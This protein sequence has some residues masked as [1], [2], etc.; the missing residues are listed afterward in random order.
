MICRHCG[1]EIKDIMLGNKGVSRL[2]L[3]KGKGNI[4]KSSGVDIHTVITYC[5]G[6]C[7][8]DLVIS[9]EDVVKFL[10]KKE[11]KSTD[12]SPKSLLKKTDDLYLRMLSDCANIFVARSARILLRDLFP[13]V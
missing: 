9:Q 4:L 12:D 3:N 11:E 7:Y 6:H 8:K 10:K 1:K 13:G 5:C 2:S